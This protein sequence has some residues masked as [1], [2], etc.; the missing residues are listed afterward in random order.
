[1]IS[2]QLESVRLNFGELSLFDGMNLKIS[3]GEFVC[4]LGP[5]GC[6]KSTLLRLMAGLLQP[7]AGE[8]K[9]TPGPLS[10]VFQEARLLPWKTVE[11]NV[12]LPFAIERVPN[13]DAREAL[14]AVGLWSTRGLF[15]H[16]LSGG[17]KQ[18]VAIARALIRTPQALLMDEPFSALDEVTRLELENLLR[19]LW[20]DRGMTLVFVTHS[21][22]EAVYLGNRI[23][24]IKP[25]GHLHLERQ[26]PFGQRNEELLTSEPFNQ[27]IRD[28]R[29]DLK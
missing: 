21:L 3:P 9:R 15:P 28:L 7:S 19:K 16:Q 25:G 26:V 13:I 12:G 4:V 14:E 23:L 29:G 6:G 27:L 1:M 8:V 11:E 17:M 22:S 20:E 24:V 10:F 18:R 2:I 5:S